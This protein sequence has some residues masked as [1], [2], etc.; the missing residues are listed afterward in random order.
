VWTDFFRE[1]RNR[2]RKREMTGSASTAISP[3]E[4]WARLAFIV[5]L[6]LAGAFGLLLMSVYG[7][8]PTLV[9]LTSSAFSVLTASYGELVLGNGNSLIRL[10][11]VVGFMAL[12]LVGM[13]VIAVFGASAITVSVTTGSFSAVAIS[14]GEQVLSASSS[15]SSS[16]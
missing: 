11:F 15:S 1:A 4:M 6:F 8:N 12:G 9:A 16:K 13:V 3:Y 2:E 10:I 7:M 14:Y 5:G